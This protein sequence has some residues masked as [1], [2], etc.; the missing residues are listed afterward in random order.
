MKQRP[1]AYE[2]DN[3]ESTVECVLEHGIH[4][5]RVELWPKIKVLE[6][7]TKSRGRPT[8]KLSFLSRGELPRHKI[9]SS[10]DNHISQPRSVTSKNDTS[11]GHHGM[12]Q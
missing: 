5:G 8:H 2:R 4:H 11:M 9:S 10:A 12:N 6:V 3:N 7:V 1:D